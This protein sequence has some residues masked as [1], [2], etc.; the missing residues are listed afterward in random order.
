MSSGKLGLIMNTKAQSLPWR[1]MALEGG[2]IVLSILFA[3][4]IDAW[5]SQR[6]DHIEGIEQLG[7][8]AAELQLNSEMVRSKIA[9]IQMAIDATSEY[10]SWMGPQPQELDTEAVARQLDVLK[11]I[12]TFSLVRR[13]ANDYLATGR[14]TTSGDIDIRESLSEWHFYADR[15]ENQYEILR[16]EHS[17]LNNYLNR[18][19]VAPALKML[20][21][22][23]FMKRHPESK[24]PFDQS[25]LLTDP[26]VESL[27][28]HYLIRMEL[29]LSQALEVQERQADLLTSIK[30]AVAE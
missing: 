2:V 20:K 25:V 24:F 1:R 3:F 4:A 18:I 13:A 10:L 30:A 29:V 22:S 6:K 7:R 14:K 15:L 21:A 19:P 26:V 12:G 27:L 8:V 17:T 28:A 16:I 9:R 11:R 23:P 5:W